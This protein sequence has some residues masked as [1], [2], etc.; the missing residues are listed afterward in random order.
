VLR[1]QRPAHHFTE[2]VENLAVNPG[3]ERQAATELNA[4]LRPRGAAALVKQR[5]GPKWMLTR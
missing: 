3:S 4:G 2:P 5:T 1:L